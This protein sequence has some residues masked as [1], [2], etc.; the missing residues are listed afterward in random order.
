M[1][2]VVTCVADT[3]SIQ[4]RIYI[5]SA[6]GAKVYD[7]GESVIVPIIIT[8]ITS[9]V[10]DHEEIIIFLI[11]IRLPAAI[12]DTV[13]KSVIVIVFIAQVPGA[14]TIRVNLE[15]IGN[16]RAVIFR[17]QNIISVKIVI[18][19]V[20]CTVTIGIGLI[21]IY[22]IWAV[23]T[24]VSIIITIRIHLIIFKI[25]AVV[26]CIQ[27]PVSIGIFLERPERPKVITDQYRTA[28][29]PSSAYPSG[30]RRTAA[31]FRALIEPVIW[32]GSRSCCVI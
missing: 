10:A 24:S 18:T 16:K 1:G 27:N 9:R 14:V 15:R 19:Q 22:D 11:D 28:S 21:I 13:G 6:S 8:L 2:A 31:L 17:I 12:V 25:G 7:I 3:V 4:V 5:G 26:P 20:A 32:I 29:R 30:R 23:V